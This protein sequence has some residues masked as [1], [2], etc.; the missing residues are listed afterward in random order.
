MHHKQTLTESEKSNFSQQQKHK[1][2]NSFRDVFYCSTH[3][4]VLCALLTQRA[5]AVVT[6]APPELVLHM[7]AGGTLD[8]TSM[9]S[10]APPSVTVSTGVT[11]YNTSEGN[12]RLC[13]SIVSHFNIQ[14][15]LQQDL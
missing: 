12:G 15:D 5:V 8:V 7:N 3:S 14:Y 6:W 4:T 11:I 10:V 13:G 1:I 9:Y 2:I